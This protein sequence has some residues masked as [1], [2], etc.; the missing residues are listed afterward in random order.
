MSPPTSPTR[1][2]ILGSG[3]VGSS[4]ASHLSF[5]TH[6]SH[7]LPPGYTVQVLSPPTLTTSTSLAPGLIGQLNALPSLTTLAKSSVR[8]YLTLPQGAFNQVGGLEIAS[9]P[10]GIKI[11]GLAPQFHDRDGVSKGLYFPSDG[12]AEPSRIVDAYQVSARANGVE[13]IEATALGI[14]LLNGV[15]KG[16]NTSAGFIG[17]DKIIVASGIWSA[18]LLK[19]LFHTPVIPVAHPYIHGSPRPVRGTASPFVRWPEKGVYGR[20]HG[21]CE[22][23]RTYDHAPLPVDAG[24]GAEKGWVPEFDD[25][26]GRALGLFPEETRRGLTAEGGRRF[27]GVFAVTPDGLPVAGP[28]GGVKGLW[29]AAGVWVTHAMGVVE[30]IA[31]MVLKEERRE[32]RG[33]E[34]GDEDRDVEWD[35][36]DEVEEVEVVDEEEEGLRRALDPGRFGGSGVEELRREAGGRYND[37]YNLME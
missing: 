35:D 36:E 22:G 13:F 18:D 10:E 8:A 37:I 21:A 6:P 30:L 33:Y 29:V 26:V 4:L 9:T 14:K 27:N 16:V 25:A 3:V 11:A 31:K 17:A 19:D 20:D 34:E 32:R 5:L 23:F 12:V 24:E 15:A 2:L 7:T 28:V 1:I